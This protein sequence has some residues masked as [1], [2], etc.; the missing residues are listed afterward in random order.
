MR[1][2]TFYRV[3]DYFYRWFKFPHKQEVAPFRTCDPSNRVI[4][5]V[6]FLCFAALCRSRW[7]IFGSESLLCPSRFRIGLWSSLEQLPSKTSSHRY[8]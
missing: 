6:S 5:P 8:R 1:V 7:S 3:G 4:A 2:C